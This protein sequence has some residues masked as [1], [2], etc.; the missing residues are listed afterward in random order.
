MKFFCI[1]CCTFLVLASTMAQCLQNIILTILL[2]PVY[3]PYIDARTD[4]PTRMEQPMNNPL[5]WHHFL[6]C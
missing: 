6:H 3:I 1:E 2:S 4:L 5:T